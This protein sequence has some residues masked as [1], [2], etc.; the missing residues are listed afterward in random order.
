MDNMANPSDAQAR[1]LIEFFGEAERIILEECSRLLL[2][3]VEGT[4]LG[5]GDYSPEILQQVSEDLQKGAR[6]WVQEA[7]PDSYVKGTAKADKNIPQEAESLGLQDIHQKAAEAIAKRTFSRLV[8][9]ISTVDRRVED[10]VTSLELENTKSAVLGGQGKEASKILADLDE[11]GVTGFVDRAGHSWNMNSYVEVLAYESTMQS[12]REGITNRLM[13][14]AQDLVFI[15][16]HSGS[17]KKCAEF[18]G[19]L[20]SLSGSDED[21]PA[22]DE[23]IEGGMFHPNCTHYVEAYRKIAE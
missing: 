13:E 6:E 16:A 18:E 5:P 22:L 12:F 23:A 7:I 20:Y 1:R 19:K 2:A 17:C 4:I 11:K 21:Y 15:P 8:D 14:R 10:I 9:V 3:T